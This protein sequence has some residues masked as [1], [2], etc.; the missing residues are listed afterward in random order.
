MID[1][2]EFSEL[3]LIVD[4]REQTN[5][6]GRPR[7]KRITDWFTR[8]GGIVEEMALPYCDYHIGG[9]YDE[10]TKKFLTGTF[11]GKEISVGVEYK[12][13]ADYNTSKEDLNWK[14]FDAGKIFDS[15]ALFVQENGIALSCTDEGTFV[16][17]PQVPDGSA[18]ITNYYGYKNQLDTF[19]NDGVHIRTFQYETF[20]EEDMYSL[21]IHLA[22]DCHNGLHIKGKDFTSTF[23]NI[24]CKLDGI[25]GVK[26][27][28]IA[29]VVPNVAS[30]IEMLNYDD[31]GILERTIGPLSTKK[32]REFVNNQSMVGICSTHCQAMVDEIEAKKATTT[33]KSPVVSEAKPKIEKPTIESVMVVSSLAETKESIKEFISDYTDGIQR[34]IVYLNWKDTGLSESNCNKII[35][36]LINEGVCTEPIQGTIVPIVAQSSSIDESKISDTGNAT[37]F[38]QSDT[39]DTLP[40]LS[41]PAGTFLKSNTTTHNDPPADD[42]HH[43]IDINDSHHNV[44]NPLDTSFTKTG[45]DQSSLGFHIPTTPSIASVQTPNTTTSSVRSDG[46]NGNVSSERLQQI[47]DENTKDHSKP[48]D[49]IVSLDDAL[50]DYCY[51]KPMIDLEIMSAFKMRGYEMK[52]IHHALVRLS[53]TKL[54]KSKVKG[55]TTYYYNGIR[56]D[57]IFDIGLD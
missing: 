22:K 5:V 20:F 1:E 53:K 42:S 47:V 24:L 54:R 41:D 45:D 4:T 37:H 19:A 32:L 13:F 46:N 25:G 34:R 6:A 38:P 56:P 14:L 9:G 57:K 8:R 44:T 36:E 23:L 11:R 43:N 52:E 3:I 7:V 2:N 50:V 51:N 30:L 21:L 18:N 40:S 15:V 28:K 49:V 12:T 48:K 33:K 16:K 26:A 39:R 31:R 10:S 29:S 55:N 35:T 17:I 27:H